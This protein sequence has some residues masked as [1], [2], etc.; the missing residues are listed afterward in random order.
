LSGADGDLFKA[1]ASIGTALQNQSA[2]LIDLLLAGQEREAEARLRD[3]EAVLLPMRQAVND[4]M[5]EVERLSTEL[6]VPI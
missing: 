5:A 2:I 6:G 4:G 3:D 1:M